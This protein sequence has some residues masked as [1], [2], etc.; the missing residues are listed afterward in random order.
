MHPQLMPEALPVGQ[1]VPPTSFLQQRAERNVAVPARNIPLVS[2][3]P[4]TQLAV[5]DGCTLS[6]A[7]PTSS[8]VT[9]AGEEEELAA[10]TAWEA[11]QCFSFSAESVKRKTVFDFTA[12]KVQR[13][14]Q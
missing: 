2:S 1:S 8:R 3:V 13:C 9:G 5:P 7:R 14:L 11:K 6:L 4:S 12:P 10:V